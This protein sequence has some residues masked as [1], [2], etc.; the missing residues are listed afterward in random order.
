MQVN[1]NNEHCNGWCRCFFF[2]RHFPI[3]SCNMKTWTLE[4]LEYSIMLAQHFKFSYIPLLNFKKWCFFRGFR[5]YISLMSV[6]I[7]IY[8]WRYPSV[9]VGVANSFLRIKI[10]TELLAKVLILGIYWQYHFWLGPFPC[11]NCYVK[12]LNLR[13][14]SFKLK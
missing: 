9:K 4:L 1:D 11:R 2:F 13:V 3:S 5:I 7:K 8:E 14:Q 12:Y 10:N 6:L